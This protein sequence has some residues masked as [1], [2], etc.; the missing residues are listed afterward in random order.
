M[1][2]VAEGEDAFLGPRFFFVPPSSAEGRVKLVFVERFLSP[3]VFISVVCLPLKRNGS[4]FSRNPS[5]L[6]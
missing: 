2:L 3:S 1:K 5:S 6:M 4:M